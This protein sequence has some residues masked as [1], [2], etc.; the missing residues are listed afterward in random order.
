MYTTADSY[1]EEVVQSVSPSVAMLIDGEVRFVTAEDAA[2][3]LACMEAEAQSPDGDI[4]DLFT[5]LGV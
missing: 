1:G 5:E 4:E 3:I 2:D